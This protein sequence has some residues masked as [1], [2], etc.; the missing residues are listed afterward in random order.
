MGLISSNPHP[1]YQKSECWQYNIRKNNLDLDIL[2]S[3]LS[4][5]EL[6]SL[7]VHDFNFELVVE[8]NRQK[9]MIDFIKRHEWL[10]NISQ[11]TT[12][13]FGAYYRGILAGVI[14]MNQPNAFSKVLGEET[15]KIER[16]ISRGACIS[17]SPKCLASHFLMWCINYMV[18]NTRFRVFSAYSDTEAK[19]LGTI[20]Q[21]CNFYY[22][23]KNSG[24]SRKYINPYNGKLVSDRVFRARSFYKKYAKELGIEWKSNWNND[25]KILW[26]NIPDDIEKL[27]RDY[28]KRVQQNSQ[29]VDVPKKHKYVYILGRGKRE[30]NFL[31]KKFLSLNKVY[32]YPKERGK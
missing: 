31:R 19:E 17:W 15:S 13:W 30:T 9:E 6:K 16:L 32:P 1:E 28:S 11:F 29:F 10:G 23:G 14:L 8:K 20:Y 5:E 18:Q 26:Q 7:T 25:Q 22:L 3:G 24:T 21:S 12:H 4:E 2:F 27:L